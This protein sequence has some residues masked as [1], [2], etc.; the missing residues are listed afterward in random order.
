MKQN[1]LITLF[2]MLI[3]ITAFFACEIKPGKGFEKLPKGLNNIEDLIRNIQPDKKYDYWV[4]FRQDFSGVTNPHTEIITGKGD[5]SKLMKIKFD[6]PK[7][8]FKYKMWRGYYYIAY[9]EN[10]SVKLVTTEKQLIKFIGKIKSIE[11]ALVLA[12]I[13]GLNADYSRDI[14]CA[15][16]KTKNGYAFY[17]AKFHKCYVK[18]EP[19]TV[20]IDSLGNYKAKSLGFYYDEDEVC[21][22]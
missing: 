5:I 7:K 20:S 15:Y 18:T 13:E 22:D 19:F 6:D 14:G 4:C 2:F 3:C 16:Q 11:E 21:L 1:R 9:V 12:D 10:D 8:G 17:L